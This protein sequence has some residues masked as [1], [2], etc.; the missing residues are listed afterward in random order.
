[1]HRFPTNK[2]LAPLLGRGGGFCL[3]YEN[4]LAPIHNSSVSVY[5]S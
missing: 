3:D 2:F 5:R 1:M 4:F